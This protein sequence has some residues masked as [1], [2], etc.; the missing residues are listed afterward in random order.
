MKKSILLILLVLLAFSLW[1]ALAIAKDKVGQ[2]PT[3]VQQTEP[4]VVPEAF[5]EVML[6]QAQPVRPT[7]EDFKREILDRKSW[8]PD[9]VNNLK[10]QPVPAGDL[11]AAEKELLPTLCTIAN[12]KTG[13]YY[14]PSGDPYLYC[15]GDIVTATLMNPDDSAFGLAMCPQPMYPFMAKSVMMAFYSSD[16]ATISFQPEIREALYDAQGCAYPGAVLLTGPVTTFLKTPGVAQ[17]YYSLVDS[18]CLYKPWFAVMHFLNSDDFMDTIYCAPINKTAAL[19]YIFDISGRLCQSYW[20]PFG[21]GGSWYDVVDNGI[22]SGAIRVRTRGY[23][24]SENTCPLPADPWYFKDSLALAPCGVPDFDQAQ[25]PPAFCGPVAE[26][27]SFWWL[28]ARWG[29]DPAPM[30]PAALVNEI[31]AAAGTVPGIGTNCDSLGAAT[32]RVIQAHG[33]WW[34]TMEKKY[35]PDF[36]WLQRELKKCEDVTLLLGF[37]QFDPA[38]STWTRFGGHFI[39]LAGVDIFNTPPRFAFSDPALDK[40]EAMFPNPLFGIVCYSGS[41]T[42]SHDYYDVAWPSPS[43]GGYLWL[44]YYEVNWPDFNGQNAGPSPNTGTYDPLFPVTV[45]VEQ[46][47]AV[48]PGERRMIGTVNSTNTAEHNNNMGGLTGFDVLFG[49]S[50]IHPLYYGSLF[51]GISQADLR[52][53]YGN[54]YPTMSFSALGPPVVEDFVVSGSAGPYNIQMLTVTFGHPDIAGLEY[55]MHAFGVDV[56]IGGTEDCKYVI[57]DVYIISNTS[58]AD[59]VDLEKALLFDYDI[60]VANADSVGWDQQH[61]SIWM[62]DGSGPDTVFGLT[63]IPAIKG[64]KPITGWGLINPGRIYGGE[65]VDSLKYW[66]ENLG[67]GTD[68]PGTGNDMSLLLADPKFTVPAGGYRI[69]KYIKWGYNAVIGTG[70]DANWRHF[71]YN[72]LHQF[73]YYRGDVDKNGKFDVA[74]I[75]YLVNYLFKGGPKPIEFVDQGDVDN[76]GNTN[77]ADVIFM[78]NNRFKG[79]PFP[80]DKERFYEAAPI[81]ANHKGLTHRE[82]LFNDADWKTLGQ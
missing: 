33:G 63:E 44:P 72:V 55:D 80:I 27:N 41:D 29:F 11:E 62:W 69:N 2:K 32:L 1:S 48:S 57:E 30:N 28:N 3:Q 77:V 82:S 59:I 75:I 45:E 31:A 9:G 46:A 73:G 17:V 22:E 79:G 81:P 60:G 68:D 67:W 78:V 6:P 23:N 71:L 58:H 47:N 19:S 14:T 24:K 38:T 18:V 36:W 66:M 12:A 51:S 15:W 7:Q 25:F 42:T 61:A 54:Y 37:W 65:Y 56:P 76:N 53:D 26:A 10:G 39:T 4:N 34:F 5:P 13:G 16:T 21:P 43:P 50:L 74:D 49:A 40:A 8:T 70:G 64:V 20:N 52:G 35:K